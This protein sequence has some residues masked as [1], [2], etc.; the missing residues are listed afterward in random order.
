MTAVAVHRL[1]QY[2]I[3]V[4]EELADAVRDALE[5]APCS[6]RALALEAGIPPS[7]ITR[8]RHG[9]RGATPAVVQ[10]LAD[11]LARWGG[12]CTDAERALRRAL[13]QEGGTP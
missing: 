2:I 12:R 11:A 6:D 1:R 7:T 8:I 13:E 3:A 4:S 5:R 9:E 10:A